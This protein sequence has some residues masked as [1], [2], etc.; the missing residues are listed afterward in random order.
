MAIPLPNGVLTNIIPSTTSGVT[1]SDASS[2]A[3]EANSGSVS[4]V[5]YVQAIVSD[6]TFAVVICVSGEKRVPNASR[7]YTGQS[8]PAETEAESS[9]AHP[10]AA[11]TK[12][13]GYFMFKV[14]LL[15][16]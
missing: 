13:E 3:G 11:T 6:S 12:A 7:P 2:D 8:V 14:V 15:E 4:R 10:S 1:S 9:C 16:N 5:R